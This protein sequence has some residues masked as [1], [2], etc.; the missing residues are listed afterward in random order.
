[1]MKLTWNAK[2][3]TA[4]ALIMMNAA[5]S[6]LAYT[7]PAG[8]LAPKGSLSSAP[9]ARANT[10][11]PPS[12]PL[13]SP[14]R[15]SYQPPAGTLV[16]LAP[17]ATTPRAPAG[18]ALPNYPAPVT[19]PRGVG[20]A[21]PTPNGFVAGGATASGHGG[22]IQHQD[23]GGGYQTNNGTFFT[24]KGDSVGVGVTTGPNGAPIG[25]AVTGTKSY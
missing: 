5:G 23:H 19:P 10:I 1:M 8:T 17:L 9:P 13:M 25:G 3:S 6:A 7:A 22:V 16:P 15:P 12:G 4:L 11:S 24:P 2:V 21:A 14:A 18:T 20:F